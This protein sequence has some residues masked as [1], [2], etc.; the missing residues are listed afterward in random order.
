[1]TI[2][3]VIVGESASNQAVQNDFQYFGNTIT[4]CFHQ[5]LSELVTL[6]K[7]RVKLPDLLMPVCA[8]IDNNPKFALYFED[9][10]RALDGTHI[11]MHEHVPA[12]LA[13]AYR[14]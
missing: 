8:Q 2:F 4:N 12:S 3:F 7:E 6:H 11:N 5:V 1:M 13:L 14:N 10:L 9:C